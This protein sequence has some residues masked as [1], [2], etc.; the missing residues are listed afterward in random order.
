MSYRLFL[1]DE[2][3]PPRDG[4]TWIIARSA[5]AA[6]AIVI[7]RGFPQHISFDNDL[8]SEVE[9]RHFALWLIDQEL[10]G[11]GKFP[12]DFTFYVHSQNPVAA[13]AIN[14]LLNR[15]LSFRS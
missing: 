4:K 9:G 2:R 11:K 7:A 10:E 8:G 3:D 12:I 14:D 6:Q 13:K 15:Y 5:N 1:D